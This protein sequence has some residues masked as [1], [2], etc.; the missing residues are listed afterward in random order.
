MK[1]IL[2]IN[3]PNLNMLGV[4]EPEIY[5]NQTLNDIEKLCLNKASTLDF[6]IDFRQSNHEGQ[7]IDW[8]QESKDVFD[9][10][11]INAAAYTHTSI[12]IHDALK[13]L[14]CP[15]IEVHL[16]NPEE[17]EEFRH[18]SY[19]KPVSSAVIAGHGAEGYEM[20]LDKLSE[21]LQ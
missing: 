6:E 1:K 17:R 11:V 13:L 8:I 20:A 3:G 14:D 7:I 18:I 12:A 4:R 10:L 2:I 9:A 21:L 5:G 16:S 15:I 19:I